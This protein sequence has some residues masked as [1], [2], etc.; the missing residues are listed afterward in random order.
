MLICLHS[1]GPAPWTTHHPLGPPSYTPPA[2]PLSFSAPPTPSPA[3]ISPD[4]LL[5]AHLERSFARN[6]F[7]GIAP[8]TTSSSSRARFH[9]PFEV[10]AEQQLLLV[11][12]C[13]RQAGFDNIGDFG[14][15]LLSKDTQFS[16][17]SP[18]ALSLSAFVRCKSQ[19]LRTHPA[20]LVDLLFNH[21]FAQEYT[22]RVPI[23]P[24]F[25]LP[26]HA[27]PPSQR[28]LPA[29][30]SP[31][32]DNTTRN[33]LMNWSLLRVL[34]R[35]DVEVPRLFE[36]SLGLVR[37]PSMPLSWSSILKWD[38]TEAQEAIAL[39]APATFAF[40]ATISVNERS[41]KILETTANPQTPPAPPSTSTDRPRASPLLDG[42]V[43]AQSDEPSSSASSSTVNGEDGDM[44]SHSES[45][46][47]SE[48]EA[49]SE[50]DILK[51]TGV[52][53]SMR[54]DP[55]LGA[56]VAILALL[57]FRYRYA[58]MFPT[59]I[60]IF[61]FTCNAHHDIISV[62]SR[63]GFSISQRSIYSCLDTLSTDSAG[64]LRACG[65]AL[66]WSPPIFLLLYDNVN[67]MRRAW[68]QTLGHK[69]EVKSG[70]A[71]TLIELVDAPPGA[72][73]PEPVL[74][75]LLAKKRAELTVD[76]LLKDINT[77]HIKAVSQGTVLR[78][79]I[80]HV[81]SL[82]KFR[83]PTE[84]LF[85]TKHA[86][87]PL[88]L[89]KSKIHSM[90][91]NDI[92][93]STTVGTVAVIRNMLV[94]QLS[95]LGSWVKWLIMICG[96][97][98]TIDRIR[99]V[100]RYMSKSST[101]YDKHD[102]ALPV[103]QLWHLKWN[104]QKNIFRLHWHDSTGATI[105]GLRHDSEV[106]ERGKF[107]AEKCDFYPGHQILEDRFDAMMLDA[108]RLLC[109]EH[110]GKSYSTKLPLLEGLEWFF[111]SDGPLKDS[112]FD[113]L[114]VFAAKVFSR[115]LCSAAHDAAHG[116]ER[117]DAVYGPPVA[118]SENDT[119]VSTT[120]RGQKQKPKS[121]KKKVA[122]ATD[123]SR[124]SIGEDQALQT[125]CNFLRTTCW[126]LMLCSA[127]AEGDI[128]RVFEIIKLLR[129]SFWGAGSTNY[130]TELLE[131]ACNFLYEFP[132][133]LRNA[134]LNNYLAN[135]SGLPGHWVEL[136]LIQEH[137]NFWIK[138]LF[139]SKSHTFDSQH[140]AE[141]VG[142]NIGGFSALRERFP[143]LFGFK[144]NGGRHTNPKSNGDI[145]RLGFHYRLE[146]IMSFKP[147]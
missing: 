64:F 12:R 4:D 71:C 63:T 66:Q 62:L 128:G 55:W 32:P 57:V 95:V 106:M 50:P 83:E 124:A 107:N 14:L 133:D 59:I 11:I 129:F 36:P 20:A 35:V 46:S 137:Y 37:T 54:R 24:V 100:K 134:I 78:V 15:A 102:F 19:D 116:V 70:T 93:E 108:L 136:D 147:N 121:K 52:P 44:S 21:R 85:T 18:V 91:T 142:L 99:K 131:M 13:M 96:D 112:T 118:P 145:N 109:E 49:G 125:T 60:G 75:N 56:T 47:E 68:Q 30:S 110:S 89:R 41:R 122:T 101:F 23:E 113:L 81:P 28:L 87:H 98:L 1:P 92:D 103:I 119:P 26:R 130:G 140:L 33:A 77:D 7:H 39:T 25:T 51:S 138:R 73:D 42:G 105:F 72:L 115:Y 67:K 65:Q 123:P 38:L 61:L 86:L 114:E 135:P 17:N 80:K 29:L 146:H 111:G 5:C 8:N 141:H 34:E 76:K 97:Q 9:W 88:S 74:A 45:E 82:A 22:D 139:N 94:E 43:V 144:R 143:I 6:L 132:E 31:D 117:T 58:I 126:Y 48:V 127:I 104:W 69:D 27:L 53:P 120:N 16:T 40:A 3:N 84:T 2:Y 10:T 90:R 79:W